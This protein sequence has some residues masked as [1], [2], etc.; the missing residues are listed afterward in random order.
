MDSISG[1]LFLRLRVDPSG[2]SSGFC[3]E[4]ESDGTDVRVAI[5]QRLFAQVDSLM[6]ITLSWRGAGWSSTT[7]RRVNVSVSDAYPS[8]PSFVPDER[9]DQ[10]LGHMY[11]QDLHRVRKSKR[12]RP[13]HCSK[14]LMNVH[15]IQSSE[16]YSTRP[17]A[18]WQV[19]QTAAMLCL[20]Y[21]STNERCA[22][23]VEH[24]PV[25]LDQHVLTPPL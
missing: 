20:K 11:I 7:Y 9:L 13:A 2:F 12:L 6:L 24:P 17:F 18:H 21:C 16:M 5:V 22:R 10:A 23:Y 3:P 8:H 1:L 25:T 19:T 4:N 15:G 14:M